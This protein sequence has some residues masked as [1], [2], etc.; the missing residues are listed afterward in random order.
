MIT[1]VLKVAN[2]ILTVLNKL[3]RI[4]VVARVDLYKFK[5]KYIVNEIEIGPVIDNSD[6]KI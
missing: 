4:V 2:K 1:F 6:L 5:G 3:D